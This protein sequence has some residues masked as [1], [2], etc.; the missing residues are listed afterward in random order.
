MRQGREAYVYEDGTTRF[1]DSWVAKL[2]KRIKLQFSNF[3]KGTIIELDYPYEDYTVA[4][5]PNSSVVFMIGIDEFD[6][7]EEPVTPKLFYQVTSGEY[8]YWNEL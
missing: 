1:L 6:I 3:P 7:I 2:N 8:R 5:Q 4:R